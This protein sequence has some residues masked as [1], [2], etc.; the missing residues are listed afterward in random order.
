M[1]QWVEYTRNSPFK[2]SDPFLDLSSP[3]VCAMTAE[4]D[5]CL[6]EWHVYES[7]TTKEVRVQHGDNPEH[8]IVVDNW[9]INQCVNGHDSRLCSWVAEVIK[10]SHNRVEAQ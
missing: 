3:F 5:L 8:S 7:F 9:R 6:C 4:K 2:L 10:R 1:T